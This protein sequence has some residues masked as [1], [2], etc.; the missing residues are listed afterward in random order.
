MAQGFPIATPGLRVGLLGGSFDPPHAGH[1]HVTRQALARFGLDRVWWLV[2][3][4][5]PIKARGPAELSARLAACRRVMEHPRV[6]VTDA[7]A[8]LGTARTRDTLRALVARYPGVR[9][10]WLMGADN[11]A[12]FHRWGNWQEIARTV[13]IGVLPRPGAQ[14]AALASPAARRFAGARVPGPAARGLAFRAPP[15]WALADGPMSELSSTAL[16]RAGRW[17]A[18]S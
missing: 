14:L 12:G 18:R 13:P 2:S 16:R 9:F 5:N 1:V 10:V 15:A 8:R 17:P 11:L 7:E 3:P 6:E 4:G